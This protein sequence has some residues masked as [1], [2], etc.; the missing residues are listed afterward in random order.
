LLLSDGVH[1]NFDPEHLGKT[2]RYVRREE[3]E[4]RKREGVGGGKR[5]GDTRLIKLHRECRVEA[6]GW[7]GADKDEAMSMKDL[8]RVRLLED[9]L[10]GSTS[11][12][13]PP[14][15]PLQQKKKT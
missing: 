6:D 13:T 10:C 7:A 1:D 5:G 11:Y 15:I 14:P 2:P 9:T 12:V 8:Y 3:K 4:E